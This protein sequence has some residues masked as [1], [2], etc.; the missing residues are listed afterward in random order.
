[1]KHSV[2]LQFLNL[3]QLVGLLGWGIS[4]MQDAN[5]KNTDIH[6]L[7]GIRTHD[8]SVRAG[9]ERLRLIE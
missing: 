7:S 8:P 9:E 4:Q 2:S 3:R 1:M 5:I 6:T